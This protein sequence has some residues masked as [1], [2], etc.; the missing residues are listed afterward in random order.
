MVWACTPKYHGRAYEG[1]P[2]PAEQVALIAFDQNDRLVNP[3][4]VALCAIDG[5]GAKMDEHR[6]VEVLPGK[7]GDTLL[8]SPPLHLRKRN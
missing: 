7:N 1:P 4:F 5:E 3:Q 6:S 2:R 8:N